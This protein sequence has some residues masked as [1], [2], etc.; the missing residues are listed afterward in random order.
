MSVASEGASIDR[1]LEADRSIPEPPSARCEGCQRLHLTKKNVASKGT[2]FL[3]QRQSVAEDDGRRQD[4]K[5]K[6]D[7]ADPVSLFFFF[8][9]TV[10]E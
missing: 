8:N 1:Y 7:H 4:G 3:P 6:A 9:H 10:G 5:L 2:A